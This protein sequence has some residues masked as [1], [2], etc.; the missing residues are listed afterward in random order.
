M[1]AATPSFSTV[2]VTSSKSTPAAAKAVERGARS[3]DAFE[4]RVGAEI[5][6][7]LLEHVDRRLRERVHGVAPD[8]R[9]DVE[10][11]GV[12]RVL[13]GRRS[14]QRPLHVC[15]LG[16]ERIPSRPRERGGEVLVR[17]LGVRDRGA[18]RATGCRRG[19][20]DRS[21]CR[22]GSRRTTRPT[23]GARCRRRARRAA[24]ALRR[25]RSPLGV[26]RQAE[27]QGHVHVDARVERGCDRR[28]TLGGRG[29]LDHQVRA[30]DARP[31]L[32]GLRDRAVGVV[33]EIR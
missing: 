26:A 30:V 6:F 32:L 15:T 14:P 2:A 23:R 17:E 4:H 22:R 27:D 29:D 33:C 20:G 18:T 11:G 9:V 16:C 10:R 7:A 5:A 28:D 1:N 31:Q 25:T 24:R 21:R 3:V 8:Q 13:R 12:G 19:G